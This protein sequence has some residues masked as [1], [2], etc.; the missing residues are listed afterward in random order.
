MSRPLNARERCLEFNGH[1]C[2]GPA[3]GFRACEAAMARRG[4]TLARDE[5]MA[6][7]SG[8]TRRRGA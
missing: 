5:E 3:I 1:A 8:Y 7:I 6:C 2:P 4:F